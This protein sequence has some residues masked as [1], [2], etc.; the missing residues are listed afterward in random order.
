MDETE[1]PLSDLELLRSEVLTQPPEAALPRNLSD[2]WLDL[3]GR[4]L[5]ECVGDGAGNHDE[6]TP[7]M[8]APLAL[9]L[10]ILTGKTG[11]NK[12]EVPLDDMFKYFQDYRIE[13][14]LESV[15]RR[16]DIRPEA[17]TLET[18][19][20]ERDVQVERR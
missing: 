10:H 5:E 20:T 8:T 6:S 3:I 9:I 19:F 12:L 2:Y 11:S 4:D 7:Y 16:T 17:A 13:I 18:I 14:A 1:L 15:R